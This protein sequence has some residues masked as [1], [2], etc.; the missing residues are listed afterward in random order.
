MSDNPDE[1][2]LEIVQKTSAKSPPE[3]LIVRI[4]TS[5]NDLPSEFYIKAYMAC[6]SAFIKKSDSKDFTKEFSGEQPVGVRRKIII[7]EEDDYTHAV[8]INVAMPKLKIKKENVLGLAL[9]PLPFLGITHE[10]IDYASKNIGIYYIGQL[11][12]QLKPHP[13]FV[14]HY[15]Y[16][17]YDP[18]SQNTKSL[19]IVYTSESRVPPSPYFE[20]HLFANYS[21]KTRQLPNHIQRF[22]SERS[23]DEKEF[24]GERPKGVRRKIDSLDGGDMSNPKIT[25]KNKIM[26]IVFS[27]KQVADGHKYRHLLVRQI[28]QSNLPIDIYGRGCDLY[29][30]NDSRIKGKFVSHEPYIDYRFH[31]C[32]ENYSFDHYFSEKIIHPLLNNTVPIYWGCKKITEYFP[33]KITGEQ[34]MFHLTGNVHSDMIL[35]KHICE[36]PHYYEEQVY[37]DTHYVR[38]KVSLYRELERLFL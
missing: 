28:L 30:L 1:G 18:P 25:N 14:E 31:I 24:S 10:F 6:D 21:K 22:S 2:S 26:S 16:L 27:H 9:E 36:N 11:F 23:V 8:I 3:Q 13:V 37:K 35:L 20:N 34:M 5:S 17:N 7:T 19:D 33:N 32:I 38:E 29:P 4:F 12:D 15:G